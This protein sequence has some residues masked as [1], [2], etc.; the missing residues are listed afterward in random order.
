MADNNINEMCNINDKYETK[1]YI[2]INFQIEMILYQFKV[3]IK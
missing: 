2:D 3:M 1:I